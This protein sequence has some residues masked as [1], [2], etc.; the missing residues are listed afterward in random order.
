MFS[1][2]KGIVLLLGIALI[3]ANH[4]QQQH[5]IGNEISTTTAIVKDIFTSTIVTT[6]N[7]SSSSTKTP[8]VVVASNEINITELFR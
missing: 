1:Q 2:I 3:A 6:L 4:I 5:Q 7:N 8:S